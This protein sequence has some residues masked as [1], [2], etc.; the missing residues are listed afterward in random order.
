MNEIKDHPNFVFAAVKGDYG[1][2][3][4]PYYT[5]I[6]LIEVEKS[7][8][9]QRIRQRSYSK[10]E[11]R[12]MPGGDLYEQE[13]SFF[14]FAESRPDD[15]VEKWVKTLNCPITRI[16]GTKD[17]NDIVDYIAKIID[18]SSAEVSFSS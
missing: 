9:M 2:E 12:M 8:R 7:I 14:A 13:E 15:T 4:L 5:H 11:D 3:I 16:D 17:V 18:F 6:V 1:K 10:F